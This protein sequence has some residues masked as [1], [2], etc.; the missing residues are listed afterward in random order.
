M[1][2]RT[3]ITIAPSPWKIDHRS[4]IVTIGSCF[5]DSVACRMK[6]GGLGV[7]ANPLGEMFN[8]ESI[9]ATV[10]RL[11]G[12]EMFTTE[13]LCHRGEVWFAYDSHGAF[14]GVDAERVVEA[15]NA[16]VRKGGEALTEADTVVLT[17]GTAW[18]F[19]RDG[20][21]VANCH[22]MPSGEFVRRRLSVEEVVATLA[23]AIEGPLCG[24]RVVLTVSPVRH[25]A[26]GLAGNAVSKS[27]LRVAAELLTERYESVSYFPSYE[28]VLDD[29]R[30]YRFAAADLVHPTEQAVEYVWERFAECY[31][32]AHTR[33]VCGRVAAL[34]RAMN[35][36]P[37]HGPTE[38]WKA[39]KATM[40]RKA[41]ELQA[42]AK[43]C[44][45]SA[46]IAFFEE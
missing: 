23:K 40:L 19:E 12:G 43:E 25:L 4:R 34:H 1:K 42:E 46:E 45:L 36:R 5:A 11:A 16:A 33:E 32:D 24:K 18:V 3:E 10:E 38:E 14:D 31:M 39:F 27:I 13:D 44:D 6:D 9:V 26:D 41:R 21:V 8:P 15:L 22:K 29:L 7:C 20:R 37:L 28:I 17:L 35:H 2:F 30:D